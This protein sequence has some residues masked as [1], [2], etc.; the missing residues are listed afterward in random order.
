M[1]GHTGVSTTKSSLGEGGRSRLTDAE[2]ATVR[3]NSASIR[4]DAKRA[5]IRQQGVRALA[6]ET[7][8][9]WGHEI[10]LG[11]SCGGAGR[12]ATGRARSGF[13]RLNGFITQTARRRRK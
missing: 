3:G 4:E 7:G 12:E 9:G 5:D 10:N 8:R 11:E 2:P 13:S 6:M 1:Y